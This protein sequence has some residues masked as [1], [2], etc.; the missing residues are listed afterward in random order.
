[1]ETKRQKTRLVK[2]GS[3]KIGGGRPI[4]VQ[5]MC[6]TPTSRRTAVLAEIRGMAAAG[7]ELVRLAIRDQRDLEALVK[8]R[9]SSPLPIVADLHFDYRL[10]M[11]AIEQGV[12]K[13]RI[14]PGNLGT[15]ERLVAIAAA[16][17]Q[18]QV[19]VRIGVN[20]GSLSAAARKKW[21]G[22]SVAAMVGSALEAVKIFEAAGHRQLVISLKA[23]DVDRTIEAYRRASAKLPYPMHLGVTEAGLPLAAAVKS[24]I[25]LGTLLREGIGDTIRVSVTGGALQE[26]EI[27]YAILASLS[28]RHRGIEVISCPVCGRCRVNLARLAKEVASLTKDLRGPLSVAVMGCE[29]NGPGEAKEADVGVACGDGVG[30]IFKRGKV[31]RKVREKQIVTSLLKEI[32]LAAKAAK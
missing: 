5:S 31:I 13:I 14:N 2:V 28:L 18:H 10:V 22:N 15:R 6:R 32:R 30:L 27:A 21:R 26:I 25:A 9:P 4:V 12:D 16:A 8:L 11:A 20:A 1:M 29:V 17:R 23:S 7:C 19:A 24:A 3:L